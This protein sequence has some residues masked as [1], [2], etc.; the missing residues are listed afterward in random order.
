MNTIL[1]EVPEGK[2]EGTWGAIPAGNFL[3][4]CDSGPKVPVDKIVYRGGGSV[5]PHQSLS[6]EYRLSIRCGR[7]SQMEDLL[8]CESLDIYLDTDGLN[9]TSF[10]GLEIDSEFV[11]SLSTPPTTTTLKNNPYLDKF[12][13][14]GYR[15]VDMHIAYLC[16][17]CVPAVIQGITYEPGVKSKSLSFKQ[18]ISYVIYVPETVD[19]ER[20]MELAGAGGDVVFYDDYEFV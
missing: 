12:R 1:A 5:E 9:V 16:P 7:N 10:G 3:Y 6:G 14:K 11:A 19:V 2:V 4:S 15:K 17:S 18:N 13:G 20:I 8:D